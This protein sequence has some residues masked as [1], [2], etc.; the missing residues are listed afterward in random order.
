VTLD[1]VK[2]INPDS[3]PYPMSDQEKYIAFSLVAQ[4]GKPLKESKDMIASLVCTSFNSGFSL[5]ADSVAAGQ[6]YGGMHYGGDVKGLPPVLIARAGATVKAPLLTGMKYVFKDW[7]FKNIEAGTIK[8][9]V[10]RI[11]AEKKVFYVELTR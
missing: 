11:P 2:I 5:N 9:G 10:L 6:P 4:D 8:N 1:N 7:Y 3:M